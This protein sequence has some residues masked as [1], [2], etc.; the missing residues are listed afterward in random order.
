MAENPSWVRH[1]VQRILE[2]RRLESPAVG[3]ERWQTAADLVRCTRIAAGIPGTAAEAES[4]AA[5]AAD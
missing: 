2:G 5:E 1:T 4:A 3:H